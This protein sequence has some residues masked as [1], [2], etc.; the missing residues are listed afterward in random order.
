METGDA[1]GIVYEVVDSPVGPLLLAATVAGLV[2]VA[3]SGE[4]HGAVLT[5]LSGTAGGP[6]RR[7][8]ERLAEAAGE[9]DEY[10]AGR[11]DVFDLPLDLRR[12]GGFRRAV[13][14]RLPKI[15]R[16][17]TATYAEVAA[18]TGNPAAA[19]AVGAACGANPL[20][21]VVPCHRVVRGDGSLGGYQGGTETKRMLLDLEASW[22]RAAV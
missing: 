3:F 11:R 21:I 7:R 16:G 4:D 14:D 15:G 19:R 1:D 5:G 8:P 9:L 6:A 20:P 13:L 12:V 18:G 2:R 17:A 10:F 22:R